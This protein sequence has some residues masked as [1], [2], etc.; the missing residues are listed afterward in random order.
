MSPLLRLCN[1]CGRTY[2]DVGRSTG[3]CPDCQPTYERDK[4]G[5][6]RTTSTATTIRDSAAWKNA[7]N[8]ARARDGGCTQ[9]HQ[10]N[11]HGDLAVHH[12]VPIEQGGVAT[13][14]RSTTS[15]PLPPPPR[16][17]RS[18]FS[19]RARVHPNSSFSRKKLGAAR[20]VGGRLG[21]PV[22]RMISDQ[23]ETS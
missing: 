18:R 8:L 13:H 19:E 15:K 23:G 6:R 21:R 16:R 4:S 5:R 10:G 9:R 17:S 11:C 2:P 1:K 14:S 3:K 7:R 22:N 12:R 20:F